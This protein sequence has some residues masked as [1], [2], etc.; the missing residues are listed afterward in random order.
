MSGSYYEV[1]DECGRH[2]VKAGHDDD[3]SNGEDT[4]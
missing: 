4:E 2:V 1:C 3:C